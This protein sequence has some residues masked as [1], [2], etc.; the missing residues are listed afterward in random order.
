MA[1]KVL[2]A[3]TLRKCVP[4]YDAAAGVAL[5]IRSG[6]CVRDVAENLKIPLED[7]RVI[8]V[9]GAA[10]TWETPLQPDDRVAFFPPVGGG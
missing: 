7:V 3:A 4:G 10:A 6:V 1:L 9:N 8:M 2:L 5:E